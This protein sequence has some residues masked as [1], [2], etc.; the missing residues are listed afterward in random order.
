VLVERILA[1]LAS[2]DAA[3]VTIADYHTESSRFL[4]HLA[5]EERAGRITPGRLVVDRPA[6]LRLGHRGVP[7]IL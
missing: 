4:T 5:R 2:F 6:R 1:V 3:A 7:P